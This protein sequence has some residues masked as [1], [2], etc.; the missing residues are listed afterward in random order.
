MRLPESADSV[1]VSSWEALFAVSQTEPRDA[2]AP[3][4]DS[5]VPVDGAGGLSSAEAAGLL[6][7]F[8]PNE[9]PEERR[10]LLLE[11]GLRFWGPIPWMIEAAVVLT[12]V[13]ER[14]ADFAVISVL[15]IMN[16][17][18]GFW[19]EHQ[20]GNAIAALREQ[21]AVKARVRR[22]GSWQTLEARVLVPGDLVHVELGQIVPADGRLVSG[23]CEVDESAL[24]GESLPAD[25]QVGDELHSG[26]VLA[27]G[28]AS[29]L[30]TETGPRTLF[31]QTAK[32]AGA[33]PPPS[34]F[35][36]AVLAIGR[37]LIV[38]ALV[39]V[40]VI[41][42]VSLLRGNAVSTTLE[43]ALVVT[44]AS[45]PV[46]LPAVLS[47]TMAIGARTLAR[48]QAV[49]SHLPAVEELA[50]VDILCA[51]KTGTITQNALTLAEPALL[52]PGTDAQAV[53]IAAALASSG[54]GHD[55]IDLA[56]LAAVPAQELGGYETVEFKPFDPE[57]KRAQARVRSPDGAVFEVA[58]GAPQA[59][60]KLAAGGSDGSAMDAAVVGLA[61]RGFRSLAVARRDGESKDWRLLGVLPLHDPPREDSRAT[62]AEEGAL[63]LAVKMVTGDRVEIA[64]EVAREV[65]LG[66]EILEAS[67]LDESSPGLAARVEAADGYAQVV[68]EQKYR[69][70]EA[71][72]KAGHIV[73]MTGDGVNDAP[74]LRRADAGVAVAG[75]TDA[76]RA[77]ADVVLLAP[78]L[79]VIVEAL[80]VSRQ[81]FRRMSNY[82]I[83]RITET[84]RVVIF[85]TLAIVAL[86]F[87]PVTA[88]M[89]VLLAL[90]NDMAILTIAFDRVKVSA[91]PERWDMHEVLT[92]SS[93]LGLV[94]VVESFSLLLVADLVIGL[95]HELLRTLMY[96]KLSVAGSLTLYIARTRGPFWSVRP[97]G[98][99]FA[100][101]SFAELLATMIA[102]FGLLMHPLPWR[103]VALAWGWALVWFL[104]LDAAKVA[105]YRTIDRR[106]DEATAKAA[107]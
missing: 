98:I 23:A 65:G 54:E 104:A 68:P 21:L 99:L 70:V 71:L 73:A 28:E 74:A 17:V 46:A 82:A 32:L 87:F 52:D 101:V 19:E 84:I 5:E 51:D 94:G 76:A 34:H 24:T 30:V 106:R 31:G 26:S 35:Q 92:I 47:V 107:A 90:L 7:R 48:S 100:A 69:I 12:T 8:G 16:G 2:I 105:T 59:I 3:G 77:A 22:D 15:L 27:R 103:Y 43:F 91:L 85:V 4:P 11:V 75:A 6:E 62:I 41:V 83:Y 61:A 89:I 10:S 63:G 64:Q 86:G 20:A 25:K 33:E 13:M 1:A 72:Q 18:V 93:L 14:W 60:A 96:L 95:D 56:I 49:V 97:A 40:S 102:H 36:Q 37:Y 53:K 42:A 67:A 55:P 39:L 9:I 38:L 29:A 79:S 44:I 78:G 57:S 88:A 45:V 58:K 66:D 50:G 80:G 81:I